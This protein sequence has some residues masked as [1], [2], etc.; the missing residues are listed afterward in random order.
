MSKLD[1]KQSIDDLLK[2]MNQEEAKKLRNENL[3]KLILVTPALILGISYGGNIILGMLAGFVGLIFSR[4]TGHNLTELTEV[5]HSFELGPYRLIY[6]PGSPLFLCGLAV[7]GIYAIK[8][9][10]DLYKIQRHLNKVRQPLDNL[11]PDMRQAEAKKLRNK[12]LIKLILIAP[13]LI[14]AITFGS[15]L[16][17]QIIVGVL[18]G[19]YIVTSTTLLFALTG[20]PDSFEVG[21]FFI[22]L[23]YVLRF[24]LL[25]GGL[26]VVGIYAVRKVRNLYK[27]K[28]H[29]S[30]LRRT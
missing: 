4:L 11:L 28:R 30:T 1:K 14:L 26:V 17:A 25:T 6:V 2:G 19:I 20:N 8:K 10:F 29:L 27:I 16:I 3:V 18:G 22:P 15:D 12:E 21:W 13:T 7:G 5:V 23:V 9:T 24:V